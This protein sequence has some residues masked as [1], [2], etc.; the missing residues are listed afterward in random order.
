[1][2]G[3]PAGGPMVSLDATEEE[4]LAALAGAA[5]EGDRPSIAAVNG[6]RSVVISGAREAVLAV[7]ARFEARGRRTVRLRVGHAFHSPLVEP[8]LGDFRRIAEGLDF[9]PPR[10]PVVSA[11][12]GRSAEA[13]ELC[14]PEYWV[15][16]ARRPVRFADAVRWLED[17]GV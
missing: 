12:T 15:R 11:L 14:S 8:M 13:A 7:A 5:D 6:P 16:H 10:I 3:R 9:R 17:N 4:V 2:Q 1:M